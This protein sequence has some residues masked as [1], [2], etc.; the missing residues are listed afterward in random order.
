MGPAGVRQHNEAGPLGMKRV[1]GV[2][3][4]VG[5]AARCADLPIAGY[6]CS[7]RGDLRYPGA[8]TWL[9][10]RQVLREEE[11][12]KRHYGRAYEQYCRLVRRYF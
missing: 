6:R 3:D 9:F 11:Y 7:G 1:N 2:K 10:H 8:A 12:L 5:R 4:A